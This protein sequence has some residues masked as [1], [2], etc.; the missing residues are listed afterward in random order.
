MTHHGNTRKFGTRRQVMSGTAMMTKGKL[1][2]SDLT[3]KKKK[4]GTTRR[5][6]SN[7]KSALGKGNANSHITFMNEARILASKGKTKL[8]LRGLFEKGSAINRER[9]K[10]YRELV[11][12]RD[13]DAFGMV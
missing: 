1:T 13:Q 6:V 2:K 8:Q 5:I 12:E 10:I 9:S 11:A 3:V 4:D 7:K